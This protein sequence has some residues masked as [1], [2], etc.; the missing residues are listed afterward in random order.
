MSEE[1]I[2]SFIGK[3]SD[4]LKMMIINPTGSINGNEISIKLQEDGRGKYE[5]ELAGYSS[6]IYTA[7]IQK[8]NN[9]SSEQ[10]SVGLQSSSG[11]ID[12]KTTQTEYSQG[13]RIL[14]IG[15]TGPNALLKVDLKDPNGVK[16][17]SLDIPS[18]SDGSFTVDKLKVPSNAVNGKWKIE[19]TSGSYLDTAEFEVNATDDEGITIN[20]GE[21]VKIP[22]FGESV[23]I[24][25]IANQK[26]TVTMEVF[27]LNNNQVSESLSCTLTA[28]F[29][30][31]LLWT[32]PKEIN[33]G[34][35][36]IKVS[37]SINSVEK[38]INI[39]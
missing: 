32:I 21:I 38:N 16:I 17:K 4:V 18:N 36:V 26:T 2:I 33:P 24:G 1:A 27:D 14:I 34:T 19:V 22:G 6:G 12:V 13:E 31:Q 11:P 29:K 30:C 10:F 9:Q 8:G 7:V 28:E 35:Y 20:I 3:P 23:N 15:A 5:L 39:N 25:I 37:D